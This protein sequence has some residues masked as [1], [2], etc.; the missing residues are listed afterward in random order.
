MN[1]QELYLSLPVRVQEEALSGYAWY[2]ER[3]YYGPGYRE[4]VELFTAMERFPIARLHEYQMHELRQLL[5]TAFRCVP[6]FRDVAAERGLNAKMFETLDDL[7]RLPLQEKD[8]I[9]LDPWRFVREDVP[10]KHLW[11]TTSSGT[12]GKALHLYWART[13]LPWWWALIEV[14]VRGWAGVNQSLP[15]AMVGGRPIMRGDTQHPPYWRYNRRWQQLYL[16]S[17]HISP[18]TAPAYVDALQRYGSRWIT[19]YASAIAL[20]GEYL[21]EHPAELAMTA[22]ITSSDTVTP[23]QR[24]AIERGFNCRM[25][26]SYSGVEACGLISECEHGCLHVQPEAGILEI[27]DEDGMPCP[28]GVD[29]EFIWTGLGNDVMP[30]IRYRIG[31]CG[32]WAREQQCPCGRQTPLVAH[33]AGRT[34]EYLALP[35]GRRVG[36]LAT[37]VKSAPRAKQVQI[38]QDAPDHAWILVVPDANFRAKDGEA[39]LDSLFMRIG[40]RALKVEVRPVAHIP[41]TPAG[42]HVLVRRIHND[43]ALLAEYQALIAH[44]VG[45]EVAA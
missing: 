12:T 36:N 40:E 42:K 9:R 2:L 7:R 10:R 21:S 35:D 18:A 28:P 4:W 41:R 1:L 43:P 29:G 23:R 30:L 25:F 34:D 39:L 11:L 27:L 17:Y 15:R 16:S 37:A 45:D 14:R 32:C 20:L 6:W 26:D 19:G 31:D 33:I 22:A 38:A 3:Q 13:A 5:Y 24:Q 44:G 8:P